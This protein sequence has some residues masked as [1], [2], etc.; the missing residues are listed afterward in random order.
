MRDIAAAIGITERAAQLIVADL[1]RAG[2][3]TVDRIGRRN[4]YTITAG[5]PFRHPAEAGR[6]ATVQALIDLFDDQVP[7]QPPSARRDRPKD[8]R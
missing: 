3:L 2:Y 5:R 1:H 4:H 6:A 8:L 7:D